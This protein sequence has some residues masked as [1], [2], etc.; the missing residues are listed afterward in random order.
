MPDVG[1]VA[2][3]L[4]AARERPGWRWAA[5][6]SLVSLLPDVDMIARAL[7]AP[8]NTP[9]GHRGMTH[10][11]FFAALVGAAAF[12]ITRRRR[13]ALLFFLVCASHGALDMLDRGALGV[14][15]LWPLSAKNYFWPWRFLPGPPP[16]EQWLTAAGARV[17][18]LGAMP[19][20]PLFA[21]ALVRRKKLNLVQDEVRS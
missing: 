16:G 4:F 9:W 21:A 10:S 17:V 11:L 19:F 14:E 6:L 2:V 7:G 1:H 8:D 12:A 15:Y 5:A 18:V 20:V 3:G 13:E